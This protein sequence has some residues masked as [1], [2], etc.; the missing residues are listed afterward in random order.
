MIFGSQLILNVNILEDKNRIEAK[1]WIFISEK[2][3]FCYHINQKSKRFFEHL[4]GI[5]QDFFV[6]QI[7][8]LLYNKDKIKK[9]Y[10]DSCY[11]ML[12]INI[13]QIISI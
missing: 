11:L 12:F 9:R 3:E 5:C 8:F 1:S 7:R 4:F 13:N 2:S 10:R 6:G